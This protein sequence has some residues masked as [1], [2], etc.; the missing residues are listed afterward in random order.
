MSDLF[1]IY[2]YVKALHIVS[3]C[4][5]IG[6]QVIYSAMLAR[7][8]AL[9]GDVGNRLP[10][11]VHAV[12]MRWVN[13]ALLIVATLGMSLAGIL[14]RN[15]WMASHWIAGKLILLVVL[16]GLHGMMIAGAKAML[17][18]RP[19]SASYFRTIQI[20]TL[21]LAGLAVFLAVAKPF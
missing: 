9:A 1:F 5:W 14:G 11:P 12:V 10:A 7:Y 13:A 20:A 8:C 18:G 19:R 16:A 15:V 21:V 17:Q 2:P 4:I 3:V 6:G